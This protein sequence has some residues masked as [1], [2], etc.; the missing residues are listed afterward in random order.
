MT[1]PIKDRLSPEAPRRAS[2]SFL[3]VA[4][5]G[6]LAA[7]E[8][9]PAGQQQVARAAPVPQKIK[10]SAGPISLASFAKILSAADEAILA[11]GLEV[12]IAEQTALAATGAFEPEFYATL[13]R[14]GQTAQTSASEFLSQGGGTGSSGEPLPYEELEVEGRV[15]IEFLDRTGISVDLFYEMSSVRNSLQATANR[16]TPEYFGAAGLE[17]RAPLLRNAGRAVNTSNE[18]VASIETKIARETVRLV[19]SQRL[20]DGI[21]TYLMV[22]R[23]RAQLDSRRRVAALARRLQTEMS[24]QVDQG[25]RSQ[26]ELIEATAQRVQRESAVTLAER[27]LAERIGAFQIYFSGVDGGSGRW[28]PTD[29]LAPVPARYVARS[30]YGSLDQA[31]ARRPEARINALRLERE[32]VLRLVAEN[33]TLPQADLVFDY[34]KTQLDDDYV[35]F[36][37]I[38]SRSNPYETWRVGFEY[39]R[40]IYGD[41]AAQAELK[42]AEL[43]E[44]QAELAMSAFRQRVASE[45]NG[46]SSI[47]SRARESLAQQE[48]MIHAQRQLLDAERTAA[49]NGQSSQVEVISRQ[50][51]LAL[52]QEQRADTIVQLNLATF[53]ASQVD[54]TL[55]ERFGLAN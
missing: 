15:G 42:A 37:D 14:S 24:S 31:F 52:A 48:R 41:R 20:F 46:I 35:P 53:L 8:P 34:R 49:E 13:D 28:Q 51:N 50:I 27:E 4:L 6:A 17:V 55:L 32:E 38:Y 25:L 18:V 33:R 22:Q 40:G 12:Q 11:Q 30:S 21:S 36:R 39:R 2:R 44:A 45:L 7:C 1:K 3:L 29:S 43:R 5:V 54:G 26:T 23:A 16:P 19:T 9:H 10:A 47:L